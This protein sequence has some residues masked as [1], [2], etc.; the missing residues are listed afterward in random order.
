MIK[1]DQNSKLQVL[2]KEK[3]EIGQQSLSQIN[4]IVKDDIN[5]VND[6]LRDTYKNDNPLI[7]NVINSIINRGGKRLRP[8]LTILSYK[9]C[10]G[11]DKSDSRIINLAFAIELMHTATLLHDDVVDSSELRRGEETI[12]RI[13]NNKTS[14][15]VGDYL[16]G[17]AFTAMTK[18]DSL[19]VLKLLSEAAMLISEGEILQMN[20]QNKVIDRK[21]YLRIIQ[22]KTSILFSVACEVSAIIAGISPEK[23]KALSQFGYN[24][25]TSFQMIDDILDYSATPEILG[26]KL[27]NDFYEN[28]VTLPLILVRENANKQD[29]E[30]L[31][32]LITKDSKEQ[33]D[34]NTILELISKYDAISKSKIVAKYYADQAIENLIKEFADSEIRN[35]LISIRTIIIDRVL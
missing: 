12:N 7:S 35:I 30:I 3:L 32:K 5:R 33:Q 21:K 14:I 15:L 27:G 28:T 6:L 29:Q 34:W 11:T 20:D 25:G 1:L 8:L 23:Q 16:L 19:P 18:S 26:K 9:L 31:Y 2:T 13:W 4:R 17:C 10:C 22:R 24:I